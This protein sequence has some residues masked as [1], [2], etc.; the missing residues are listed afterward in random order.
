M[1]PS[2]EALASVT[3]TLGTDG[4]YLT[5]QA[6]VKTDFALALSA[7]VWPYTLYPQPSTKSYTLNPHHSAEPSTLNPQPSTLN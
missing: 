5:F 7:T 4:V 1:P 2:S 3:V 6:I